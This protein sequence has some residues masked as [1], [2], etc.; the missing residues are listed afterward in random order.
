[1]KTYWLIWRF[2]DESPNN[3]NQFVTISLKEFMS[4]IQDA[5]GPDYDC[6]TDDEN[7]WFIRTVN[8][9]NWREVLKIIALSE[10]AYRTFFNLPLEVK[11]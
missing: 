5:Y 1:M 9:R 8:V 2:E 3:Y 7:N 6:G 10:R 4:H 11:P